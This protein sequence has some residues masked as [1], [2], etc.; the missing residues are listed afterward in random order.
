VG[1]KRCSSLRSQRL[2]L[3]PNCEIGDLAEQDSPVVDPRVD[4][5]YLQVIAGNPS[6]AFVGGRISAKCSI[7]QFHRAVKLRARAWRAERGLYRRLV[8]SPPSGGH[9]L[10]RET[11]DECEPGL[12]RSSLSA[13]TAQGTRPV[14]RRRVGEQ[15]PACNRPL[16]S[17]KERLAG[18][19]ERASSNQ[20]HSRRWYLR[21]LLL[22]FPG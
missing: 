10:A 5:D 15:A 1:G 7:N 9:A 17:Q 6:R 18:S 20:R 11:P 4:I 13:G 22:S 14:H 12:N 8:E 19:E 16:A 3:C 2:E 21:L